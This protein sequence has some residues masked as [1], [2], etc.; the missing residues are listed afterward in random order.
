MNLVPEPPNLFDRVTTNG[1]GKRRTR[2]LTA[3]IEKNEVPPTRVRKVCG[4]AELQSNGGTVT[5][6]AAAGKS[7]STGLEIHAAAPTHRTLP[8]QL[9]VQLGN[10]LASVVRSRTFYGTLADTICEEYPDRR[11]WN[12]ERIGE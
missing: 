9:H 4:R 6:A 2:N 7:T 3:F 11:C 5:D 8:T 1:G 10:F 12:G